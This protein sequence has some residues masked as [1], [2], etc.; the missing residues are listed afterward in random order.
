MTGR[1]PSEFEIATVGSC[2]GDSRVDPER[3]EILVCLP[4]WSGLVGLLRAPCTDW[5]AVLD[6]LG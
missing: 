2:V 5:R 4:G 3:G 6:F 1:A